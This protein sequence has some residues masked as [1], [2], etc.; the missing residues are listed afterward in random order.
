MGIIC[1]VS[2]YGK[3]TI[4]VLFI[5]YLYHIFVSLFDSMIWFIDLEIKK[6]MQDNSI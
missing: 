2:K 1:I 4:F 3:I 5:L 6:L